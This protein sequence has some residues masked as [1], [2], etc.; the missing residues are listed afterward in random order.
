VPADRLIRTATAADVHG[1]VAV[2][3]VHGF[4]GADTAVDPSY[5]DLV[6]A[7]GRWVVALVDGQVVGFGGAIDVGEIRFVTDLFLLPEHQGRGHGGAMLA[8]LV[9]DAPR[10]L[11]FSSA[12]ERAVPT[13]VRFGMLP[14]WH[15][16]YWIGAASAAGPSG[17]PAEASLTEVPL[18]DWGGDRHELA[19]HWS[20]HGARLLRLGAGAGWAIVLPPEDAAGPW[21]VAR[22]VTAG[23]HTG[24]LRAVLASVPLGA[25]VQL[26]VPDRSPAATLLRSLGFAVTDRDVCCATEGVEIDGSVVAL[27][28]GLA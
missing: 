8:A 15:L 20:Q 23:D 6:A 28:P 17:A 10:R 18:A 14:S 26:C 24:A 22:L 11:T 25:R 2:A 1:L 5:R 12:H 16:E 9:G 21:Q 27:H 7:R 4:E 13:Y 3:R 19:E